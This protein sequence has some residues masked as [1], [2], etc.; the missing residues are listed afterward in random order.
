M[1]QP[2][3][4]WMSLIIIVTL[5]TC[6]E[7]VNTVS[8]HKHSR[9]L[10]TSCNITLPTLSQASVSRDKLWA[11]LECI[12]LARMTHGTFLGSAEV[13]REAISNN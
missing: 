12:F 13:G 1:A 9:T 7:A 6:H 4:V 10:D 5:V 8:R 3:P 2:F 11:A